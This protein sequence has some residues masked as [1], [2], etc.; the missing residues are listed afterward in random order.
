MRVVGIS[1][2][3]I[4][5]PLRV[6]FRVAYGEW[7]SMPSIV[8]RVAT[9]GGLV[10]WGEAVP[11]PHVTGETPASVL[12]MLAEDL[13][14]LLLGLDPRDLEAV[15]A[16]VFATVLGAPAAKAALEIA[17]SDL[18]AQAAGVAL[19][20]LYGGRT[21]P[22]R[23]L[24]SV[25]SL[26]TPAA[27]AEEAARAIGERGH[28]GLKL[29]LGEGGAARELERVRAIRAAVGDV[30]I[31]I[32][33]NQG[34]GNAAEAVATIRRLEP[35]E[36][37]WVEQPTARG[38][39]AALAEVRARV[40]VPIMA[41]ESVRDA[42]ELLALIQARAADMVNVK[43]MKC[44]GVSRAALICR[45]AGAA[46]LK[47]QIGSMVESAIGSMAGAQLATA[48]PEV[49][50]LETSG[51]LLFSKDVGE[52]PIVGPRFTVS[53]R[54]GLGVQVEGERVERLAHE[55]R[56]LGERP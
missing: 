54:P 13:A 48:R 24:F 8:A 27:M 47:V 3:A 16:R 46:G 25:V 14:P 33:A 52:S 39:I 9:D 35:F 19:C 50:S 4:D 17:L 34:W 12:A 11:D 49:V 44:G 37:L 31:R 1:L 51:P 2:Y 28:R 7:T 53:E 38:D 41:D 21:Q 23:E 45:I 36:P 18:Q 42:G 43:L 6:P 20:R 15:E 30:P 56:H 29:K 22:E 32:D 40:G 10:G 26:D 55:T 5:L